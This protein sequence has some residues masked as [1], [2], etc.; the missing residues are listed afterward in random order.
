LSW[1][2]FFTMPS[3]TATTGAPLREK[4]LIDLR[5]TESLT[6][7]AAFWPALTLRAFIAASAMSSA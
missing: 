7:F 5:V 4:M 3:F 1:P 6:R 2:I